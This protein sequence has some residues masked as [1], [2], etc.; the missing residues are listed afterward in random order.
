[1]KLL[2]LAAIVAREAPARRALRL[3]GS[4]GLWTRNA[5]GQLLRV[6][7]DLFLRTLIL[8]F[9]MLIFSRLGADQGATVLA[10]NAILYQLFMLSAL[11]LDGFESAAQVLCGEAVGA[12]DRGRFT[13]LV[14][15]NLL[16]GVALSLVIALAFATVGRPFAASF[17][18]DPAVV[19]ILLDYL[20][21]AVLMPLVGVVSFVL[22]GVFIGATWT[23]ALL[24]TMVAAFLAYAALLALAAP[25]GN[26]GLWLAF[27]LFFV[28]RAG[29][30]ALA[31]PRL[32]RSTFAPMI[33]ANR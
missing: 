4:A 7:R 8:T 31:L 1:A 16:S 13:A 18:T 21:W 11:M 23:R 29:F 33:A 24:A 30:Q 15:G 28:A 17:S 27:T 9:A 10:A 25:L 26:H 6:N 32:V 20:P 22:D 5:V 3:I 19:A 14:R 2:A 12:R